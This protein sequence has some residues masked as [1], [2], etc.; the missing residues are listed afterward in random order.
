MSFLQQ[1]HAHNYS[2]LTRTKRF[3]QEFMPTNTIVSVENCANHE[4]K[5][6][7]RIK[8][9]KHQN[10]TANRRAE[11]K[12]IAR[13]L[14]ENTPSNRMTERAGG[15]KPSGHFKKNKHQLVRIA[16][17]LARNLQLYP[18][19]SIFLLRPSYTVPNSSS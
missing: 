13:V 3:P 1:N 5:N 15:K 16:L 6:Y 12:R 18:Q 10:S 14:P 19:N 11:D 7:Q 4:K 8:F 9:F 17:K 2:K